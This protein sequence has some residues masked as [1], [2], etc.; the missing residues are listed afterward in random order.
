MLVLGLNQICK[1]DYIQVYSRWERNIVQNRRKTI[2]KRKKRV[3][4]EENSEKTYGN[5]VQK[6]NDANADGINDNMTKNIEKEWNFEEESFN[7]DDFQ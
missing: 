1:G 3:I 5:E 6:T 2:S 7:D 4:S